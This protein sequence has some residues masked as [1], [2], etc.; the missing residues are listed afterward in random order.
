MRKSIIVLA[1]FAFSIGIANAKETNQGPE[2]LDMELFR[3]TCHDVAV[4]YM[5]RVY[6]ETG[7]LGEAGIAYSY[8]KDLCDYYNQ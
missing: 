1:A 6:D 5:Q 4:D 7:S 8:A 2:T 3:L